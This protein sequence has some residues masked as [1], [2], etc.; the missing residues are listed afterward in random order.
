MR[1]PLLDVTC[2]SPEHIPVIYLTTVVL[3]NFEVFY[4]CPNVQSF[5]NLLLSLSITQLAH[6]A[7]S[8]SINIYATSII[9]LK[10]W[11]VHVD[12]V[13]ENRF[14]DLALIDH[15]T[16]AYIQEIPQVADGKRDRDPN[17][18]TGNQDLGSPDRVGCNLYSDWRKL[19]LGVQ[20]WVHVIGISLSFQVM[21]LVAFTIFIHFGLT[22][23]VPASM[24]LVVRNS[25]QGITLMVLIS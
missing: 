14:V 11:C 16:R 1:F 8:L 21:S 4:H 9:A 23:Y 20:A 12:D 6:L 3:A 19:H 22:V 18:D 25:F 13:F 2:P 5:S 15:M 10:A 24:Q 17:P 7:F